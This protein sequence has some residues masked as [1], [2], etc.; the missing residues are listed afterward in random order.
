[1][2]DNKVGHVLVLHR[3]KQASLD[4]SSTKH[5]KLHT[6]LTPFAGALTYSLADIGQAFAMEESLLV[7]KALAMVPK[8][9]EQVAAGYTFAIAVDFSVGKQLA[10]DCLWLA[11]TFTALWHAVTL[12]TPLTL[13]LEIA[14]AS[15]LPL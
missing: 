5:L 12:K 6:T 11:A 14:V 15:I 7:E 8:I 3:A 1:M 10:T 2:R 13:A 4:A 9:S